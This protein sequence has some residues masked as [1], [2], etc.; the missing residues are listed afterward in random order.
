ML[1]FFKSLTRKIKSSATPPHVLLNVPN[2]NN[3]SLVITLKKYVMRRICEIKLHKNMT[4]TITFH[5]VFSKC[6]LGKTDRHKQLDARNAILKFLEHL[7]GQKFI[8]DFEVKKHGN[9]IYSVIL[10]F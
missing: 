3:T 2:Q 10:S 6:K 8:I 9:A 1:R 4:P 5:D 7:K